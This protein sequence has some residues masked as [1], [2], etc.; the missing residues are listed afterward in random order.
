VL[1]TGHSEHTID[2][3]LRLAIPSKYRNQW[4][5]ERDGQAWICVPWPGGIIRLYPEKRFEQLSERPDDSSTPTTDESE[6][7]AEYFSLAERVELDKQG[8]I[9][10]PKL[11]LELTGLAGEVVILG[12][13]NRLEV[14][15]RAKW[16]ADLIDRFNRMPEKA[17]K[18]QGSRVRREK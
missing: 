6:F 3:K 14:R 9:V 18:Y 4:D 11:H 13:R 8:R 15:D 17:A 2:A 7:E 5:P 1:F 16:A 10:V 12:A